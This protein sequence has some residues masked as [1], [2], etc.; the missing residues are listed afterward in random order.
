M[1]TSPYQSE[2]GRE[3]LGGADLNS[4]RFVNTGIQVT[5]LL[6]LAE[7]EGSLNLTHRFWERLVKKAS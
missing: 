3:L 2:Y 1:Y 7:G 5:V 6:N 4:Y